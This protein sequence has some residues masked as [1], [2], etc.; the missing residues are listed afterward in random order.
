MNRHGAA[1]L[2]EYHRG[3]KW[4]K[5]TLSFYRHIHRSVML[6]QDQVH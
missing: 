6:Q 1:L 3:E 4:K 5:Q 2:M